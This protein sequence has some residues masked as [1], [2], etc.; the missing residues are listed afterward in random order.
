[1]L[2]GKQKHSWMSSFYSSERNRQRVG[3]RI[4]QTQSN[5]RALRDAEL[6]VAAARKAEEKDREGHFQGLPVRCPTL[7]LKISLRSL[8]NCTLLDSAW[9]AK[10]QTATPACHALN[11]R[12]GLSSQGGTGAG[13]ELLYTQPTTEEGLW[14]PHCVKSSEANQSQWI[15]IE[16][17]SM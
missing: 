17:C 9:A 5:G 12:A 15:A 13:T 6:K 8:S 14:V 10:I 11:C 4:R 2:L 1:M 16:T 7:T 3:K